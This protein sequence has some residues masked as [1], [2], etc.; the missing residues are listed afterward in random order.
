ME[1]QSIAREIEIVLLKGKLYMRKQNKVK[2]DA[3]LFKADRYL[4]QLKDHLTREEWT[5]LKME[6]LDIYR[7]VM[8]SSKELIV[9]L[10]KTLKQAQ[11]EEAGNNMECLLRQATIYL[12]MEDWSECRRALQILVELITVEGKRFRDPTHALR[13]INTLLYFHRVQHLD[14]KV[15][16]LT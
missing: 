7:E 2:A 11:L 13:F 12:Y 1:E 8:L 10:D 9:A 15:D 5:R 14:S 6:S 3:C 4:A 16:D